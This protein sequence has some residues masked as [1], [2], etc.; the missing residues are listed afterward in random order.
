ML[1]QPI[2]G[3]NVGEKKNYIRKYEVLITVKC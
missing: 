2:F 1:D 3:A